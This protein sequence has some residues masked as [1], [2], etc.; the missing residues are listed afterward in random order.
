MPTLPAF[1]LLTADAAPASTSPD[2]SGLI[3]MGVLV[4]A[5]VV[6]MWRPLLRLLLIGLVALVVIGLGVVMSPDLA[7][8]GAPSSTSTPQAPTATTP[9]PTDT[10]R[11]QTG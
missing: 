4:A 10:Q 2:R 5:V 1:A 7:P 6:V 3:A 11:A 8:A 9:V